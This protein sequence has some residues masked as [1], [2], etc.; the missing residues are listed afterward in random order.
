MLLEIRINSRSSKTIVPAEE[1]DL[2]EAASNGRELTK[3]ALRKHFSAMAPVFVSVAEAIYIR[4]DRKEKKEKKITCVKRLLVMQR[5]RKNPVDGEMQYQTLSKLSVLTESPLSLHFV[6]L[7]TSSFFLGN[8]FLVF[9][10][11]SLDS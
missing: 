2:I 4:P 9:S 6:G 5:R 3:W 1:S 11:C 8:I 7:R 10:P